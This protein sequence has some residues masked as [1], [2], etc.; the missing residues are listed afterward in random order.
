MATTHPHDHDDL[1]GNDLPPP[2]Y[3]LTNS[4]LDR[5]IADAT[6]RSLS[7]QQEQL[8]RPALPPLDEDGFPLWSE[9]LFK[10][11]ETQ[12]QREDE[13]RSAKLRS[14]YTYT[15]TQPSASSGSAS[16]PPSRVPVGGDLNSKQKENK[17]WFD[18][19][20][21]VVAQ[22][23]DEDDRR[24]NIGRP[25]SMSPQTQNIGSRPPPIQVQVGPRPHDLLA[26]PQ[27]PTSDVD[28]DDILAAGD[29][30]LGRAPTYYPM[31]QTHPGHAQRLER[32]STR[33]S[34]SSIRTMLPAFTAEAESLEGP[35]YE[36]VVQIPRS[37]PQERRQSAEWRQLNARP[38]VQERVSRASMVPY[39]ASPP[40]R[41]PPA[42]APASTPPPPPAPARMSAPAHVPQP[43]SAPPHRP[44]APSMYTPPA[45]PA[46]TS[47][48]PT[49]YNPPVPALRPTTFDPSVAYRPAQMHRYTLAGRVGSDDGILEAQRALREEG[50]GAFYKYVDFFV[51]VSNQ[52]IRLN[53]SSTTVASTMQK[54]PAFQAPAPPPPRVADDD[55]ASVFSGR[56]TGSGG[57]RMSVY[58]PNDPTPNRMS[59][60]PPVPTGPAYFPMGGQT[61][62]P[63]PAP[64]P[65]FAPAPAPAPAP[66]HAPMYAPGAFRPPPP[67]PTAYQAPNGPSSRPLPTAP[68]FAQPNA[69]HMHPPPNGF[70]APPPP[71][72]VGVHHGK[73]PGKLYKRL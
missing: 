56:S 51:P 65:V 67:P 38:Q 31:G 72:G 23:E 22:D 28:E 15:G 63:A 41:P 47:Y 48:A 5:K 60:V 27:S 16:S 68:G 37:A 20:T 29:S 13:S 44:T 8:Q 61:Y 21:Q 3:E 14:E 40:P 42:P 66:T 50:A 69:G 43:V 11:N 7:L 59:Y 9:E 1:L 34:V 45:P 26:Q 54:T 58:A 10:Y 35:A 64:A 30:S 17:W 73:K 12:R 39:A 33:G 24:L 32:H 2:A 46:T 18:S 70:V 4:E 36:E 25:L 49:G 19:S 57:A 71:Q 52:L 55:G 53:E 6:Q 62:Q